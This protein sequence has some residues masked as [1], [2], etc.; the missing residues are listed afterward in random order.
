MLFVNLKRQIDTF[1]F[2]LHKL[3]GKVDSIVDSR[4]FGNSSLPVYKTMLIL[5][6]LKSQFLDNLFTHTC[7]HS[8][9]FVI[10]F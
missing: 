8:S 10:K 1:K 7:N 9:Y 6:R 4:I 3:K 5:S 2:G